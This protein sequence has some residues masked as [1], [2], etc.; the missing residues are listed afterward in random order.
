MKTIGTI[1]ILLL[2]VFSLFVFPAFSES[3][4]DGIEIF[5]HAT[6][7]APDEMTIEYLNSA[8]DLCTEKHSL[9]KIA[10]RYYNEWFK[11]ETNPKKQADYKALA[12]Q[13]FE[14]ALKSG[15]TEKNKLEVELATLQ[16][17]QEFNKIAFRALRP[18]EA[19]A[20]NTGL[21]M[22]INFKRDSYQLTGGVSVLDELGEVM[23]EN[24]SIKISLEGHTDK[25]GT[26][27]YNDDLSLSRASTVKKY[28]IENYGINPSRMQISGYG[29]QHLLNTS[30]PD[31]ASNRRVEVIKLTN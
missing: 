2:S 25:T 10:A 17:N 15:K 13:Y 31:D 16:S 21:N 20:V 4:E 18:S 9:Y 5:E 19:G 8:L 12:T 30:N 1:G 3:C 26:L 23:R 29:Y 27:E 11:K 28:I 14:M 22:F 24:E 6:Q 7:S